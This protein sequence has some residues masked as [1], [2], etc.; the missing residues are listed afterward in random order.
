MVA[1]IYKQPTINW[2]VS[3]YNV[4]DYQIEK[5]SNGNSFA[6][7]TTIAGKGNGENNYNYT[8]TDPTVLQNI[9]YYRIKQSDL[10]GKFSYSSVIKLSAQ[11]NG[12]LTIYPTPFKE[13][14]TVIS[15]IAQTARLMSIDGR[16]IKALQLKEGN[17]LINASQLSKGIYTLTT[18]NDPA[19]N[20]IKH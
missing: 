19:Q 16:I 15:P 18:A 13:S 4:S 5:S 8:Y 1:P 7:I 6:G 12:G 9:A 14:F 2:R 10:D 17:N 20:I 3:E 11:S